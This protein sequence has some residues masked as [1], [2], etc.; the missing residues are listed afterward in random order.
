MNISWPAPASS[1]WALRP[2]SHNMRHLGE[3]PFSKGHGVCE[4]VPIAAVELTPSPGTYETK[5][6]SR[7]W[8]LSDS[9]DWRKRSNR[10]TRGAE[11]SDGIPFHSPT[12]VSDSAP[13]CSGKSGWVPSPSQ[14]PVSNQVS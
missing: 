2:E 4:E 14:Q 6:A 11:F 10:D 1:S 9:G 7:R 12:P 5:Q 3:I 8:D 13:R